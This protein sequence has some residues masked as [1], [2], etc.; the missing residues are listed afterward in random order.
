MG[1]KGKQRDFLTQLTLSFPET[2]RY[3]LEGNVGNDGDYKTLQRRILFIDENDTFE[4]IPEKV[5]RYHV[6]KDE[7][8]KKDGG[9]E[10]D[11]NDDNG[12]CETILNQLLEILDINLGSTY[13]QVSKIIYENKLPWKSNKRDEMLSGNL[14]Y[15][16]YGVEKEDEDEEEDENKGKYEPEM[17]LSFMLTE[18]ID[19]SKIDKIELVIYLYEIQL[20]PN[21][22]GQ[23]IGQMMMQYLKEVSIRYNEMEL[24]EK[25]NNSH[26]NNDYNR[27]KISSIALTVFSSN[28]PAFKFYTKLGFKFTA[29]SPRDEKIVSIANRTRRR[30]TRN[31]SSSNTNANKGY[32]IIKPIYY[33]L[34]LP[35]I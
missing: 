32:R 13:E 2:I 12:S 24:R 16:V 26:N 5:S 9:D 8:T 4:E 25:E 28:E 18:E 33:L 35:N 17:Y 34:Y 22:R 14:I 10:D 7:S 11:H 1:D 6:S 3:K 19:I 27:E 31:I 29:G 21:L 20:L 15:I 23:G 30:V